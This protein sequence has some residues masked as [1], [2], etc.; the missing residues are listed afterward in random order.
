MSGL[1][2]VAKAHVGFC[3]G[4]CY[5]SSVFLLR[6]VSNGPPWC[7][8]SVRQKYVDQM[9]SASVQQISFLSILQLSHRTLFTFRCI[10]VFSCRPRDGKQ[11]SLL[12]GLAAIEFV[13][14]FEFSMCKEILAVLLQ[15]DAVSTVV[16]LPQVIKAV[17]NGFDLIPIMCPFMLS[18]HL[19]S[20]ES[21]APLRTRKVFTCICEPTCN[22]FDTVQRRKS[23]FET[24]SK[25]FEPDFFRFILS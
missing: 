16:C 20:Q 12:N 4:S 1:S 25:S 13:I 11:H 3:F 7:F 23:R 8:V 22:Q 6:N 5:F 14:L 15:Y 18:W 10:S 21:F 17:E 24:A 19:S 2:G 9:L